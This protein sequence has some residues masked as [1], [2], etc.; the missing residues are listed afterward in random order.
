MRRLRGQVGIRAFGRS[1]QSQHHLNPSDAPAV[2]VRSTSTLTSPDS[3]WGIRPILW[4]TLPAPARPS[5]S[6]GGPS[7]TAGPRADA[8]AIKLRKRCLMRHDLP[9]LANLVFGRGMQCTCSVSWRATGQSSA[10]TCSASRRL[11]LSSRTAPWRARLQRDKRLEQA[12]HRRLHD[13]CDRKPTLLPM[14][15]HPLQRCGINLDDRTVETMR[16][17]TH[18]RLAA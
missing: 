16:K 11:Q 15:V 10:S 4:T 14:R 3:E 2:Q 12:R 17:Q 9:G 8:G 7:A 1:R 18:E 5:T 6:E 13:C